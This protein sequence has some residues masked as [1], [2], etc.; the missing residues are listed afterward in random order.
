MD[1]QNFQDN[2]NNNSQQDGVNLQKD[3]QPNSNYQDHTGNAPYGVPPMPM[4]QPESYQPVPQTNVLAIVG[5]ILGIIS[6]PASCFAYVGTIIGIPGLIC[7]IL[8]RKKGKS[9][10][11]IAGII[12]SVIGIIL[13]LVMTVLGVALLAILSESGY[14]YSY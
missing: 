7:S 11:S 2:Q 1:N 4:Y 14:G 3:S 10:M 6:I 13:G 8:S 9:G 5:M 12:C